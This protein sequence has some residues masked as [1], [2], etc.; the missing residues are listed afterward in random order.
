MLG[1]VWKHRAGDGG[2]SATGGWDPF[3][4][5]SDGIQNIDYGE[6]DI[7]KDVNLVRSEVMPGNA[8][9][10]ER[11]LAQLRGGVLTAKCWGKTVWE[12][13]ARPARGFASSF[14]GGD[15]LKGMKTRGLPETQAR[16]G[17]I[18]RRTHA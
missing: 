3:S 6:S 5:P 8:Y 14:V 1:C 7:G 9:R 10:W 17:G 11:A 4:W 13:T 2:K 18:R 15:S 16:R 12:K